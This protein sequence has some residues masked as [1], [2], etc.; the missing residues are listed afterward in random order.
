MRS[1]KT[2]RA[3]ALRR[4]SDRVQLIVVELGSSP[5]SRVP[6]GGFDQTIAVTQTHGELP[7]HFAQRAL[8]RLAHVERRGGHVESAVL[9]PGDR[10]D[11]AS[12]AAR[13]LVVLGLSA[14]AE[15]HPGMSELCLLAS[16]DAEPAARRELLELAERVTAGAKPDAPPVR[17]RFSEA[18][19]ASE[20]KSGVYSRVSFGE[21]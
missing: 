14:H 2:A 9:L 18:S 6:S 3:T 17:I 8:A 15:A 13:H 10:H 11:A 4:A 1:T 19:A 16:A 7:V 12:N 20:P 21:G 5:L